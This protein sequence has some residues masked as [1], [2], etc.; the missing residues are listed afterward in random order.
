MDKW[1]ATPL[2][3]SF[4]RKIS[5]HLEKS[6]NRVEQAVCEGHHGV[7]QPHVLL[8]TDCS[9]GSH[10]WPRASNSR[11]NPK[12]E[13]LVKTPQCETLGQWQA[14]QTCPRMYPRWNSR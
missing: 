12:T 5:G 7:L 10:T 8:L 1:E 14:S 3:V 9:E 6:H 4:Q 2:P 11:D 13:A